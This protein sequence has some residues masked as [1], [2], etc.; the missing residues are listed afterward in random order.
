MPHDVAISKEEQIVYV[1][2][3]GAISIDTSLETVREMVSHPEYQPEYGI[4]IDSRD[5]SNKPD[6]KEMRHI[7]SLMKEFRDRIKGRV[8]MV[9]GNKDMVKVSVLCM[10]LRELGIPMECFNDPK[11]A[12][13]YLLKY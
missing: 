5:T 3:H 6:L 7:F 11:L 9:V 12:K 8:A 2:G 4:M 13:E 10:L 1:T